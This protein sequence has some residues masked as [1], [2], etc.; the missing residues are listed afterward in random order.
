[1]DGG[2]ESSCVTIHWKGVEQYLTVVVIRIFIDLSILNLAL[3]GV[4]GL[5]ILS[6]SRSF[7]YRVINTS[8]TLRRNNRNEIKRIMHSMQNGTQ[9]WPGIIDLYG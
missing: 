1:M 4:K 2:T 9:K 3:S 7:Q 6:D 5:N 8:L